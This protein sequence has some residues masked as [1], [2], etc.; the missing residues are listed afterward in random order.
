[1]NG[2]EQLHLFGT[3]HT[4]NDRCKTEMR[5]NQFDLMT[6]NI[7]T[8]KKRFSGNSILFCAFNLKTLQSAFR[9]DSSA[10]EPVR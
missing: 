1:M 10:S 7:A 8:N 6:V 5:M 9:D 3:G 4:R 2:A